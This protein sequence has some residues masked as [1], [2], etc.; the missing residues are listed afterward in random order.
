MEMP[1]HLEKEIVIAYL[2]STQCTYSESDVLNHLWSWS[3][4]DS[5]S[6]SQKRL[7]LG[8]DLVALNVREQGIDPY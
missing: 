6:I 8:R 3:R 5:M 7:N 2:Y 4:V 1:T